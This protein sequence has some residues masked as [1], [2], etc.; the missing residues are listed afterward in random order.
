[1]LSNSKSPS[2][3][4]C[5]NEMDLSKEQELADAADAALCPTAPG[6]SSSRSSSGSSEEVDTTSN[7]GSSDVDLEVADAA[8]PSALPISQT[9]FWI[10]NIAFLVSGIVQTLQAFRFGQLGFGK[11]PRNYINAMGNPLG[12]FLFS[13]F[14]LQLWKNWDRSLVPFVALIVVG[15]L[16]CNFFSQAAILS[17]GSGMFQVVYSFVVV[18]NAIPGHFCMG[19]RLSI[20]RW[21]AIVIIVAS[22]ALSAMAQLR[23]KGTDFTTQLLGTIAALLSTAFV[24]IV[25]VASNWLLEFPWSRPVP[26]PLVLAQ[27]LGT[28]EVAIICIYFLAE[29]V[30]HWDSLVSDHIKPGVT[31]HECLLNYALYLLVCGVHQYAFYYSCSLGPTGAVTA[32]VNKCVQ[33]A[34]LFFISHWLFCGVASSQCLSELK[35]IGAVGVCAGVLLYGY[36]G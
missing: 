9:R 17:I 18:L 12:Q 16:G 26:K 5:S 29:V 20:G 19:K 4:G 6:G 31:T 24:S 8:A 14:H 32:G 3:L 13:A 27:M 25:Y 36:F 33:T 23:L 30:P 11:D 1:M 35:V 10:V 2:K 21:C 7:E 15:E 28:V 34:L 22:V